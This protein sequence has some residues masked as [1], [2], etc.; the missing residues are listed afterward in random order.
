MPSDR[1]KRS[2]IAAP[3]SSVGYSIN[4]WLDSREHYKI[5]LIVP[6][7]QFRCG[8]LDALVPDSIGVRF[9]RHIFR[10]LALRTGRSAT[11][12]IDVQEQKAP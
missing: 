4:S 10:T 7:N 8:L 12:R 2:V 6:K 9:D 3:V 5:A 11:K 1:I